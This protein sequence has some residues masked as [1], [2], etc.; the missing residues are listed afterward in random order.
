MCTAFQF[1]KFASSVRPPPPTAPLP[2]L[3]DVSTWYFQH[4]NAH[5]TFFMFPSGVSD[6]KTLVAKHV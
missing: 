6:Y 2:V 5:T 1:Q 3:A 4:E